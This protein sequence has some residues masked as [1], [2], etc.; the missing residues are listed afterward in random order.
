MKKTVESSKSNEE[1]SSDKRLI[2]ALEKGDEIELATLEIR[3]LTEKEIQLIATQ[4]MFGYISSNT[5][6]RLLKI[7]KKNALRFAAKS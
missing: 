5:R 3:D 1:I 7:L 4:T 2:L 6:K